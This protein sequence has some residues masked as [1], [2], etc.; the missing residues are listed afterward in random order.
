MTSSDS[1]LSNY[2]TLVANHASQ[3]DPEVTAIQELV[4]A[5]MQELRRSEQTLVEAQTAELKR[6]TDALATDV[7]CLLSTPELRAFVEEYKKDSRAWYSQK[8]DSSIA[9]DPTTWLLATVELPIGLS[10]YQT[11]EDPDGYDDER[12]HILYSYSLCLTINGVERLIEVPYKRTYNI[13]EDRYYSLD[14][15]IDCYI[16][17]EVE[18]FLDEIEYPKTSRDQLVKELSVLIGYAENILTLKPRVVSFEYIGAT[19][20]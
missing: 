1:I 8:S 9:D 7:R 20:R 14:D 4:Q 2:Q 17:G 13:N 10:N 18:D 15:Q 19:E 11:Q 12:H 3:F 6:I 5:R 16:A